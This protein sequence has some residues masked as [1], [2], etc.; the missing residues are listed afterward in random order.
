M[1][2]RWR[3]RLKR[4]PSLVTARYVE[5]KMEEVELRC[6]VCGFPLARLAASY[7]E[8]RFLGVSRNGGARRIWF[9]KHEEDA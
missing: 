6:A 8:Q 7:F 4:H 2:D 5:P 3:H 1:L 9:G